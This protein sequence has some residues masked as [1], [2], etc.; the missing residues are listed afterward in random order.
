MPTMGLRHDRGDVDNLGMFRT[1]NRSLGSIEA[2]SLQGGAR[3][4]PCSPPRVC[5]RCTPLSRN[6]VRGV[7]RGAIPACLSPRKMLSPAP[8]RLIHS[9]RPRESP[10]DR[11]GAIP[12]P[13]RPIY[14]PDAQNRSC[15][16]GRAVFA[17][18]A[19]STAGACP[20]PDRLEARLS[21]SPLHDGHGPNRR[22]GA[23][24]A[25]HE[26]FARRTEH[27]ELARDG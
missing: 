5:I 10:Q 9:C 17:T 8:P 6:E 22:Y 27:A 25:A 14:R 20:A 2:T 1:V 15:E 18:L 13:A 11:V 3:V 23:S 24:L 21:R 4:A 7:A 26:S 12:G 16:S 19:G